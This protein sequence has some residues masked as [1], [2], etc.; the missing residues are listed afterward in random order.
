M[1]D[2]SAAIPRKD[3]DFTAIFFELLGVDH[4]ALAQGV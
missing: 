4:D 3:F 2:L 1:D